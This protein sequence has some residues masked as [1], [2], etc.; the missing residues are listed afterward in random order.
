[1]YRLTPCKVNMLVA[2]PLDN[3]ITKLPKLPL[4]APLK[5]SL[6]AITFNVLLPNVMLPEPDT[7]LTVA[8]LVV[9]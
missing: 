9:Y 2:E 3:P 8:A 1:M 5:I 7:V 4:M 6:A